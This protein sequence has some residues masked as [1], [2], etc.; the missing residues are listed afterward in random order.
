MAPKNNS[1]FMSFVLQ[2]RRD[3]PAWSHKS[4]RELVDLCG[5]LWK[6]EKPQGKQPED[7][8][9]TS[10][11]GGGRA[12]EVQQRLKQKAEEAMMMVADIRYLVRDKFVSQRQF[13]VM[14]TNV[15]YQTDEGVIIPA[16]L[17]LGVFSLQAGLVQDYHTFVDPGPIPAGYHFKSQELASRTHRI[18]LD[19]VHFN[20]NYEE[21]LTRIQEM[22]HSVTRECEGGE[23]VVFCMPAY[24]SQ[25]SKVL[26]WLW[27]RCKRRSMPIR[28]YDL[29]DL[30][31]GLLSATD[32]ACG[33]D[34]LMTKTMAE[35]ILSRDQF[36]YRAGIP[37]H[38]HE[39]IDIGHCSQGMGRNWIYVLLEH[40]CLALGITMLPGRHVP[41]SQPSAYYRR[42]EQEEEEEASI[43]TRTEE[44]EERDD[45]SSISD[46]SFRS[47]TNSLVSDVS[48]SCSLPDTFLGHLDRQS[49]R[50]S[51]ADS[52]VDQLDRLLEAS[53]V[54]SSHTSIGQYRSSG[55]DRASLIA[56]FRQLST[57]GSCLTESE[58][59][60]LSIS[61]FGSGAA[62]RRSCI[63]NGQPLPSRTEILRR[64]LSRRQHQPP[65]I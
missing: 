39:E 23:P 42:R 6:L 32:D 54:S 21:I 34:Y 61:S 25:N 55:R 18:P 37:C 28:M 27:D 19:L 26:Q 31:W 59:D 41:I 11:T 2:Q 44:E 43:I 3:N 35:Q 45:L 58:S 50:G 56:H 1:A 15:F 20:S 17:Y 16:E 53:S 46:F 22:L 10:S 48:D 51:L 30:F 12:R 29:S 13:C 36:V 63:S 49:E 8:S 52:S 60:T 5:P 24:T 62:S 4:I 64:I 33:S 7:S 9:D 14:H 57:P 38:Y 65:F 47:R 40:C